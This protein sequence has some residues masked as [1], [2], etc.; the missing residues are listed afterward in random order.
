MKI[1]IK[2][3][4]LKSK[5]WSIT[6]KNIHVNNIKFHILI[7]TNQPNQ[8]IHYKGLGYQKKIQ[9]VVMNNCKDLG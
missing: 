6:N 9:I 4:K 5:K 7:S 3:K 1:I 8:V 2:I